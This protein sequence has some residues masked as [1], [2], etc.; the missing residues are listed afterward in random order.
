MG[1]GGR[2]RELRRLTTSWPHR[3][4]HEHRPLRG[5]IA[6]LGGRTTERERAR[7]EGVLLAARSA[8]HEL[9]NH[10]GLVV[11]YTGLLVADGRLPPDLEVFALAAKRGAQAAADAVN[12]LRSLT[13]LKEV[14]QGSPEGPLLNLT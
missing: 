6:V 1:V 13:E 9:N 14:N 4:R 5:R 2:R 7:L 12:R 10:L 8:E 11:G 3:L